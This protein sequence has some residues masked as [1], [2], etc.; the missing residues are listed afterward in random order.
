MLASH[1]QRHPIRQRDFNQFAVTLDEWFRCFADNGLACLRIDAQHV[2]VIVN[3]IDASSRFSD[4]VVDS[5]TSGQAAMTATNNALTNTAAMKRLL[6]WRGSIQRQRQLITAAFFGKHFSELSE[7]CI[8]H[9]NSPQLPWYRWHPAPDTLH[10][11]PE[12]S[13]RWRP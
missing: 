3:L 1:S 13:S 2:E 12:S 4:W 5:L 7:S 9:F 8:C 6:L 11:L 10:L